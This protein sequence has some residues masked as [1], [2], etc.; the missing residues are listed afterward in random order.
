MHYDSLRQSL[1]DHLEKIPD[2]NRMEMGSQSLR[3]T[4]P[5]RKIRSNADTT[6][7]TTEETIYS[8]AKTNVD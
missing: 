8:I 1:C 7:M 6:E 5:F 2:L 3:K 4:T